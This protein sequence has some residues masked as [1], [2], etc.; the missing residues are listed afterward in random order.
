MMHKVIEVESDL[1]DLTVQNLIDRLKQLV[2]ELEMVQKT[3]YLLDLYSLPANKLVF[4]FSEDRS[5]IPLEQLLE[6]VQSVGAS[7]ELLNHHIDTL[8]LGTHA[9]NCLMNAN[10]QTLGELT[11][12]TENELLKLRNLGKAALKD[13]RT[14]LQNVG[15]D[16]SAVTKVRVRGGSL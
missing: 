13:I 6:E 3:G 16:I 12:M 9:R 8:E 11:L 15:L 4:R 14:E 2:R 10:I 7:Q 1:T 5:T